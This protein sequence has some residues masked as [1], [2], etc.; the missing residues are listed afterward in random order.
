VRTPV[1]SRALGQAVPASDVFVTRST[2]NVWRRYDR[3]VRPARGFVALGDALCAFNPLYGQGMSAAAVSA[4]ILRR[5]LQERDASD[6]NFAAHFFRRQAAFLQIPWS[7]AVARDRAYAQ[8][9]GTEILPDGLYKSVTHRLAWPVFT[10]ITA[11]S[12]EDPVIEKHLDRVF[13]IEQPLTTMLRDPRVLAG[14]AFYQLKRWTKTTRLPAYA[15]A[16]FSPP[17]MDFSSLV[18]G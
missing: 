15:D 9:T 11:A 13:N 4:T 2:D 18:R 6:A 17:A 16:R 10:L 7:M 5:C 14:L 8:A 12:R 3:L 1:F